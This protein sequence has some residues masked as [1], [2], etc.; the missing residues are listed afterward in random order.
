MNDLMLIHKFRENYGKANVQHGT[1]LWAKGLLISP[2]ISSSVNVPDVVTE[3]DGDIVREITESV[4]HIGFKNFNKIAK[5]AVVVEWSKDELKAA[6]FQYNNFYFHGFPLNS[7][8]QMLFINFTAERLLAQLNEPSYKND[9]SLVLIDIDLMLVRLGLDSKQKP[10]IK[11]TFLDMC[12]RLNHSYTRYELSNGVTIN[13]SYVYKFSYNEDKSLFSIKFGDVFLESIAE[14]TWRKKDDYMNLME[15]KDGTARILYRYIG[16]LEFKGSAAINIETVIKTLSLHGERKSKLKVFNRA[17]DYLVSI[18]FIKNIEETKYNRFVVANIVSVNTNFDLA[19]FARK[20]REKNVSV[21]KASKPVKR[22]KILPEV[23]EVVVEKPLLSKE[24]A[25]MNIT[26]QWENIAS[27]KLTLL[28]INKAGW[29]DI[30]WGV[31]NS[32]E[33]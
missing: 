13:D 9:P 21:V 22:G 18:G 31:D 2:L 16:S 26:A 29:E 27:N 10:F 3:T 15:L 23:V 24:E 14:D 11:E 4:K 12:N 19:E 17:M 5:N 28:N 8:L 20:E 25:L 1:T 6:G 30:E 7:G 32:A 33:D